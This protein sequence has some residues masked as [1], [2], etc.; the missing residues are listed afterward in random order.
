M[1]TYFSCSDLY[2]LDVILC[3]FQP[4]WNNLHQRSISSGN[5]FRFV[6]IYYEVFSSVCLHKVNFFKFYFS[7]G[8][9]NWWYI[10]SQI[11]RNWDD[12]KTFTFWGFKNEIIHFEHFQENKL[13]WISDCHIWSI[14]NFC[15]I[16]HSC[17]Y[18]QLCFVY[19][20]LQVILKIYIYQAYFL[21][22]ILKLF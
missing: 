12:E 21:H 3:T 17:S 4:Y 6:Y 7:C 5:L 20:R 13:Q 16:L 18:D 10:L 1:F 2:D 19:Q 14:W 15:G 8:C 11:K 9:Q 22:D